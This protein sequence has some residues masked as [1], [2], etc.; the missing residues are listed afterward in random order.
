MSGTASVIMSQLARLER[1]HAVTRVLSTHSTEEAPTLKSR[2]RALV[3]LID[4]VDCIAISAEG[5]TAFGAF[6][7]R[8]V[9][10]EMEMN[11]PLHALL[12]LFNA[13]TG[14]IGALS[15]ATAP[16]GTVAAAASAAYSA[17]ATSSSSGL[18][19]GAATGAGFV[20]SGANRSFGLPRGPSRSPLAQRG[21][22]S[23]ESN[24]DE[25]V[26][27]YRALCRARTTIDD[28]T[29]FYL[30]LHG[31][32]K[33]DF[34]R[35]LPQVQCTHTRHVAIGAAIETPIPP[36]PIPSHPCTSL[37]PSPPVIS[38][39][40]GTSL[41][42]PAYLYPHRHISFLCKL[43]FTKWTNPHPIPHF[44]YCTSCIALTIL[45]L[46]Y[47]TYYTALAILHFLYCTCYTALTTLRLLCLTYYTTRAIPHLP[48]YTYSSSS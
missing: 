12:S 42:T 24:L 47:C 32:G 20:G 25:R 30:P 21:G 29:D 41:P 35:W 6:V 11:L 16:T 13:A 46:L 43:A 33:R 9:A 40:T 39:H 28:F 7:S 45:H 18:A 14:F 23:L 36:H 1:V 22:P 15:T 10:A 34:F 48:H 2:A 37:R 38:T 3:D 19:A 27:S 17:A 31:K 4:A 26:V 44:L 8:L 5:C